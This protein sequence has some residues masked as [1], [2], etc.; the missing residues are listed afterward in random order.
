MRKEGNYLRVL[1]GLVSRELGRYASV[2]VIIVS[3]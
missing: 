2:F 3:F 1:I